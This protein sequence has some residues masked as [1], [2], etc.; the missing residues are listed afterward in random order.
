MKL[1]K[2]QLFVFIILLFGVSFI[3]IN[4]KFDKFYRVNGINNDN[5][6]LIERYLDEKEQTYLIDNQI[7]ID[8]F[9][10]YIR[11]DDFILQNYQ[12]Y[13]ALKESGRYK[14]HKSILNTGNS[15]ATRLNYLYQENALTYANKLIEAQLEDAFLH[16]SQF[17]FDYFNIYANMKTIYPEKDY[18]YV[19]DVKHYVQKLNEIGVTRIQDLETAFQELTQSYSKSALEKLLDATVDT[20]TIKVFNPNELSTVVDNTHYIG[21]YEPKDLLLVQ[22]IP[23]VQY[24]MY[25]QSDAYNALL[26]MYADLNKTYKNFLLMDTYRSYQSLTHD[27]IGYDEFQLGLSIRVS[28]LGTLYKDFE[29]TDMSKW[30]EEHAYEYGFVLRYPKNK[31]SQTNHTYDAHIYRYVGKSLAQ[32][33][34]DAKITLEEYQNMESET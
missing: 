20:S 25:L 31:A 29:N 15:L 5:R 18:S 13:N 2:W 30:L 32:S 28:E 23:R 4:Q 11:S 1:R 33:L 7:Q 14:S 22:D 6:V 10:D 9:I 3:V 8:L 17:S 34:H 12:Y 19:S 24:A 27:C 21:C 26:N 16:E